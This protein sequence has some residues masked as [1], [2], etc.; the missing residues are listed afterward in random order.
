MINEILN[1]AW[2][3]RNEDIRFA[4]EA[5]SNIIHQLDSGEIRVAEKIDDIWITNEIIKKAIL[6]SFK[7]NNST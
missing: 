1:K 5:V 7:L 6:L 3:Q 2:R 4:K